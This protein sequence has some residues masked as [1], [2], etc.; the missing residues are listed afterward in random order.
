VTRAT[1]DAAAVQ[2]L[3]ETNDTTQIETV[4]LKGTPAERASALDRLR[5]RAKALPADRAD[6]I[7]REAKILR[8]G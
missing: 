3:V 1:A 7:L 4:A 5:Q 6:A 2:S 8:G